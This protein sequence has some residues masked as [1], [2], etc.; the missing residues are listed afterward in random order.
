MDNMRKFIKIIE[1]LGGINYLYHGTDRNNIP[2]ILRDGITAPS[3][4]GDE[5]IATDYAKQFKD[6]VVIKIR[7]SDF[8]QDGLQSN[9]QMINMMDDIPYKIDNWEDSVEYC[10]SCVY[11]YNIAINKDDLHII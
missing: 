4:W 1:S 6:G 11:E 5:S 2:S 3:Y 8:I 7:V 9:T 10:G